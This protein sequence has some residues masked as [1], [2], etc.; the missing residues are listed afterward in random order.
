M[1]PSGLLNDSLQAAASRRRRACRRPPWH[2][3]RGRLPLRLGP[4]CRPDQLALRPGDPPAVI[5][6]KVGGG[7]PAPA[8]EPAPSSSSPASCG[9]CA[10]R[11]TETS[12]MLRGA[13]PAV[14]SLA[15][16][17]APRTRQ[18]SSRVL[19]P[20][21]EP[22]HGVAVRPESTGDFLADERHA[23][24]VRPVA[25]VEFAATKRVAPTAPA[26]AQSTR[27]TRSSGSSTSV[28][29]SMRR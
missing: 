17:T 24:G 16:A 27:F 12:T 25:V 1:T 26:D 13:S 2:R 20:T 18:G 10:N 14:H 3:G 8:R 28:G 7:N 9:R 6:R 21:A 5:I 29:K 22:A 4:L 11:S 23:R 19:L 15:S